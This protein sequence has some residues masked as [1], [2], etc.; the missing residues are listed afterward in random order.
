MPKALHERRVLGGRA[1]IGAELGL[2]DH[3][4][5]R[6]AYNQRQ[7]DHPAAI[8]RQE[9]EAEIGA[10]RE[11]GIGVRQ[12]RKSR[13]VAEHPLDDQ[14]QAERQQ[15]AVERVDVVEAGQK[16]ALDDDPEN[17]HDDRARISAPQ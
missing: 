8:P 15:Q 1:Q 10:A 7:H 16:Q 3:E 11:S 6:E 4:P 5:G 17:A 12:S 2:L 14:R 9:H 13:T